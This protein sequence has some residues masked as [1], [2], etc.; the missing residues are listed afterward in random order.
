MV[1]ALESMHITWSSLG[2]LII[3]VFLN[4]GDFFLH[5]SMVKISLSIFM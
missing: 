1:S 5:Q 4:S 2:L 3:F